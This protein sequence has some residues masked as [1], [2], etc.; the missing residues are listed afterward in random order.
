MQT[1]GSSV[2]GIF[3]FNLHITFSVSYSHYRDK[4][5]ICHY[6]A[7]MCVIIM[8]I[9][10]YACMYVYMFDVCTYICIYLGLS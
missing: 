1:D 6:Y 10:M 5:Y 2:D 8:Y 3:L 4:G 9:H 7:C